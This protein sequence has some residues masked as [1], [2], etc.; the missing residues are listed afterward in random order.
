M[1]AFIDT[2]THL[3]LEEFDDDRAEVMQRARDAGVAALVMP[4]IDS[5]THRRLMDT[6][7]A[8]PGYCFPLIGV[9]PESVTTDYEQELAF[10]EHELQA[11]ANQYIGI[12]EIGIDLYWDATFAQEQKLVFG[13]QVEWALE[14][15]LPIVIH[16]RKAFAQINE[17][18]RCYD[19]NKLRGIF[20]S[21]TAEPG[22]TE[23]M[24]AF[25]HFLFGI[26][27]IVTFKKSPLPEALLKIPVERVVVE[28]DAPYLA[29][30]PKRGRRNES[31]FAAYTLQ[32]IAEVYGLTLEKMALQTTKNAISLF[33]LPNFLW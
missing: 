15:D 7:R 16:C 17:V 25:P 20:H 31:A 5:T 2:H 22:E 32:K 23:Q 33:N 27:G 13:R 26:N 1:P 4:N 30:V 29:P 10:V 24:L 14:Y 19:V 28:T 21:F 3:F 12:G 6:C 8:Y 11:H 18:L 9:H